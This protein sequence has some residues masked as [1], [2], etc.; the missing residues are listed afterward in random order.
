M[1]TKPQ[2]PCTGH[3]KT[4]G[5]AEFLAAELSESRRN[6]TA[7]TAELGIALAAPYVTLV[8]SGS[9]ANLAAAVLVKQRCGP[10]RRVLMAGF[11]FPT[12]IASFTLLG[13]DVRL[14]DTE[15][16]GFNL[17]PVALEA[18]MDGNVAAVVV[19]HFLGFPAQLQAIRNL[20]RVHDAILIQELRFLKRFG[21]AFAD[22]YRPELAH[23]IDE[24]WLEHRGRHWQVAPG[25]FR[26]MHAI[27]SL[28]YPEAARRWLMAL[29]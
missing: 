2:F 5:F 8:N 29:T 19:T 6:L 7:L 28:F 21:E 4:E 11:S 26:R 23:A 13:F 20:T 27:R 24:G 1:R 9:S 12:T 25:Q 22:T 3:I 15:P 17:D 16:G 18:E 10:R 14:V